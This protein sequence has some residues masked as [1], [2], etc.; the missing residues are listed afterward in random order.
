M[1]SGLKLRTDRRF[2]QVSK[3]QLGSIPK[4]LS[5]KGGSR[6]DSHCGAGCALADI[7]TEFTIFGVGATLLGKVIY[8]SYRFIRTFGEASILIRTGV[9]CW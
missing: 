6:Y 5:V 4:N 2:I 8:A 1:L 9:S 3:I 7:V